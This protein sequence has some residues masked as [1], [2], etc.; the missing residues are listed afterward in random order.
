VGIRQGVAGRHILQT[1]RGRDIAGADL[2]DF[3]ALAG[4]HLQ[5]APNALGATAVG[6]E[7]LIA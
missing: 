4:M 5:Q 3:R 6:H 7:H 1:D 2:L